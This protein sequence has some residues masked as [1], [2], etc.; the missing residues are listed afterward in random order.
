MTLDLEKAKK[1]I[2]DYLANVT[3]EQLNEDLVK[4]GMGFY[5]TPEE[6]EYYIIQKSDIRKLLGR[7]NRVTS[8][9]RHQGCEIRKKDLDALSNYQID[10][11]QMLEKL[12][13]GE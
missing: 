13:E 7:I 5:E 4:A 1:A 11:E 10:F 8:S 12:E 2:D 3:L 9:H 6:E